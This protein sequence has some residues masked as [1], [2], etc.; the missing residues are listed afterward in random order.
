MGLSFL[1]EDGRLSGGTWVCRFREKIEEF[2]FIT[3]YACTP[4]NIPFPGERRTIAVR[5]QKVLKSTVK[6]VENFGRI[7]DGFCRIKKIS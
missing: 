4:Q 6:M 2:F 7:R 3:P 1:G 5:R